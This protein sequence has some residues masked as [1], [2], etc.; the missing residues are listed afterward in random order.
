[1]RDKA[2]KAVIADRNQLTNKCR[3]L[4]SAPFA[5]L[6]SPLYLN[7]WSNKGK[8]LLDGRARTGGCAGEL[9]WWGLFNTKNAY[10]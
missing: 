4:N 1:M 3:R 10:P 8:A 6:N 5:D 2:D 9:I 7:K